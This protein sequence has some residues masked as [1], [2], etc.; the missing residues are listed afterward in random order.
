MKR[1]GL[2]LVLVLALLLAGSVWAAPLQSAPR[3]HVKDSTSSN[4]GGYAVLPL[5]KAQT[6]S[7]V[8]G[9]WIVPAVDCSTTP[10]S[11]S[12]YWV[13]I[14]GYSSNTVEQIG[15]DSD[16]SNGSAVYDAWYEMY[17]KYP[18]YIS[19]SVRPGDV[20]NAEVQFLANKKF[21]LTITDQNSGASF[22]TIQSS[23]SAKRT[24]AEWIAEAP[25][26]GG[27]LPL[28]NFGTVSF[29]N[30]S[31]TSGST[32]GS[33]SNSAWKKDAIIM[34]TRDYN[35]AIPSALSN[36]GTSFSVAWQHA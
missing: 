34:G 26:S 8:K 19:M 9:S 30:S 31:A 33:I 10:T 29:F 14:D 24:S 20:I 25:S 1:V 21:Q 12:S 35:K 32:I 18:V 3:I 4:W 6:F 17:P 15:T 16:C 13:G 27:V 28:A 36:N 22:S 23:P 11:Y 7:D 5:S 2:L